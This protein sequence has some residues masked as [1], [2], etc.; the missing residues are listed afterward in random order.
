M[1]MALYR[2]P[3][4]IGCLQSRLRY[5][6][7]ECGTAHSERHGQRDYAPVPEKSTFRGKPDHLAMPYKLI[8]S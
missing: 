6:M 3:S 7:F 4:N 1:F 5:W 2:E 8:E